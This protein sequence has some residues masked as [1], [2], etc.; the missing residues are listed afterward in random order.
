MSK[1]LFSFN[2]IH[3]AMGGVETEVQVY[4]DKI[5]LKRKL[6]GVLAVTSKLPNETTVYYKDIASVIYNKPSIAS[7]KIGWIEL[8]GINR[9]S[10][11]VVETKELKSGLT[12]SNVNTVNSL[13]N[14]YCISFNK[15]K[16]EMEDYYLK[17][18][19]TF[20]K[21]QEDNSSHIVQNVIED[22]ETALD[23]IK[24][25]KEL[26]DIGAINEQEYNEKKSELMKNI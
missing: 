26:L 20:E 1:L 17:I 16:N 5:E 8:V 25:L 13:N 3:K 9:N 10:G 4:S 24:K 22:K 12:I 23:K 21:Y 6:K 14:P 11:G 19:E 18:R 15:N 2:A 7:S